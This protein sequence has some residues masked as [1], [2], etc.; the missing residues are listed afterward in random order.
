MDHRQF[1]AAT[2]LLA[3]KRSRRTALAIWL[4][5]AFLGLDLDVGDA[6]GKRRGQR[7][8]RRRRHD[9]NRGNDRDRSP[10]RSPASNKDSR[11]NRL[12]GGDGAGDRSSAGGRD[13]PSLASRGG[14]TARKRGP[15]KRGNQA[16]PHRRGVRAQAVP[17]GCYPG[18]PCVPGP[19]AN[20]TGCDFE[21]SSTLKVGCVNCNLSKANLTE[22]IVV[23]ADLS[24]ADLTD[25]CL[26]DADF[27]GANLAGATTSGAVFCRTTLPDGS[28]DNSGCANGTDCCPTCQEIGSICGGGLSGDCCGGAACVNGAC[29]CPAAKP[30]DCAGVCRECC[31]DHQCPSNV[32]CDNACCASGDVCATGTE[33]DACCIPDPPQTTCAGRCGSVTNTCGQQVA[34][35]TCSN[36]TPI[37]GPGNTCEPCSAVAPCAAGSVCCGGSCLA[38]VCCADAECAPSG[39]TCVGNEC[40]CGGNAPCSG[41]TADCCGLPAKCISTDADPANCGA[42]DAACPPQTAPACIHGQ[43]GCPANNR[44]PCA[45]WQTC[46]ASGCHDVQT[47]PGNCGACD[48]ACLAAAVCSAGTCV[49][50]G[51]GNQPCGPGLTCCASGCEDL[52]SNAKNCGAC[53]AACPTGATCQ[54]GVCVCPSGHIACGGQCVAAPCCDS[55]QPGVFCGG[56]C[57][58]GIC[59]RL[60]AACSAVSECCASN[61]AGA[62]QDRVCCLHT[63]NSSPGTE[64]CLRSA[65]PGEPPTP[66]RRNS[67]CCSNRCHRRQCRGGP[68]GSGPDCY[69]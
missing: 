2:R 37:C 52:T 12:V 57:V 62:P 16:T 54:G 36:P 46:C 45:S 32:C 42:C 55:G 43:C 18:S 65:I 24:G 28:I 51:S 26:V 11:P 60:D 25:A 67:D 39:N 1:D 3:A 64:C 21:D 59:C 33:P 47:D 49:C 30:H 7:H 8:A 20:L 68:A 29:T 15:G 35:P 66:C 38:G 23:D 69:P 27:N 63:I 61:P 4:G 14:R 31:A 17:A 50:P 10:N 56:Q 53:D 34:C 19:G 13:E 9:K 40:L 5:A 58:A 44:L 22:A 41:A 6:K 48:A